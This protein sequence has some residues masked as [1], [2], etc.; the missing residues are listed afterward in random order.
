MSSTFQPDLLHGAAGGVVAVHNFAVADGGDDGGDGPDVVVV[1][2][3]EQAAA[4]EVVDLAL[5]GRE[6]MPSPARS[7]WG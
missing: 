6:L 2:G 5:V 3:A 1:P 7:W 4:D